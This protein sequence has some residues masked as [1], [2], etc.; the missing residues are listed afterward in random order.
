MNNDPLIYKGYAAVIN[1]DAECQTIRGEVININD[2]ITFSGDSLGEIIAAF[3]DAM[4]DYLEH[5]AEI[6]REPEKPFSGKISL[7][8][9]PDLHKKAAFSA[10][11]ANI[12]LNEFLTQAIEEKTKIKGQD[13]IQECPLRKEMIFKG[14]EGVRSTMAREQINPHFGKWTQ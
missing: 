13:H 7:R 12:S 3:H 14:Q 5:C 9:T 1:Y 4:D 2:M 8:I 6:G 11:I 10:K